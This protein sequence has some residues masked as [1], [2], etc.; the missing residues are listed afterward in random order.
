LTPP[1]LVREA[2]GG[3]DMDGD[4][5]TWTHPIR[6]QL[7]VEQLERKLGIQIAATPDETESL[8]FGYEPGEPP[9]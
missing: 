7:A 5:H 3:G 8:G 2:R 4:L 9:D 6:A 1:S